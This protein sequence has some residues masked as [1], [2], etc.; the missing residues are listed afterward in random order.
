VLVE[1]GVIVNRAEEAR[2]R[3]PGMRGRIAASIASGVRD[4]LGKEP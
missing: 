1:A 4:C 2:M 3:D